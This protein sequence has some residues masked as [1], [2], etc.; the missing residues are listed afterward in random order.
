[1]AARMRG[2]QIGRPRRL[3]DEVVADAY[4]YIDETGYPPPYVAALLRVSPITLERGFRR[5][6]L[7]AHPYERNLI[8][9][10]VAEYR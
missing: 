5:L 6:G 8:G 3:S 10:E 2:A 7:V 9:R 1:M 4:S